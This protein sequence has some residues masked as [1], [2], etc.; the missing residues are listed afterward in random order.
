M[1][2]VA[3]G[4]KYMHDLGYIHRDLKLSN[5]LFNKEEDVKILDFGITIHI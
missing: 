5:I 2:K 1:K 3:K 4:V